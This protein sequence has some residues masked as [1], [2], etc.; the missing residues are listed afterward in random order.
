MGLFPSDP[1]G[2]FGT[3]RNLS[4]GRTFCSDNEQNVERQ[5]L[6]KPTIVKADS[7]FVRFKCSKNRAVEIGTWQAWVWVSW[8]WRRC[9]SPTGRGCV[10]QPAA[11][12]HSQRSSTFRYRLVV[13]CL[14]ATKE[15]FWPWMF[16]CQSTTVSR[17]LSIILWNYI[18][19][20]EK[21]FRLVTKQTV[22]NVATSFKSAN[23]ATYKTSTGLVGLA[24]DPNGRENLNALANKVLASIQVRNSCIAFSFAWPGFYSASF[25]QQQRLP[26]DSGYRVEVEQ[27][28]NFI[29]KVTTEKSDV[30]NVSSWWLY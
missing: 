7:P 16:S 13:L 8:T 18:V 26:A 27:W 20:K 2:S 25:P 29:K 1:S 15:K 28:Y 14:K 3:N 12:S 21:M 24:V 5:H 11:F 30:R 4:N 22:R 10:V 6:P 9:V 17:L 19:G 23:F